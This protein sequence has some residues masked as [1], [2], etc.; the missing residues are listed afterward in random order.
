MTSA[1][2]MR[3]GGLGGGDRKSVY[4]TLVSHRDTETDA[5]RPR[6]PEPPRGSSCSPPAR[7]GQF[8]LLT[9]PHP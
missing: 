1:R 2:Q 6:R 5:E 9:H 7:T 8:G 3:A 4:D